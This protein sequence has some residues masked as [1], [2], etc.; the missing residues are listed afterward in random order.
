MKQEVSLYDIKWN[1]GDCLIFRAYLNEGKLKMEGHDFTSLSESMFGDEE[2]EYFYFFNQENT[3]KL[4]LL[5]HNDDLLQGLLD[6]FNNEIKNQE[7]IKLCKDNNIAY[8]F[9][10]WS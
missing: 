7:F 2:Y 3:K 10:S 8:D 5:L 6:F 4:S 1:N 9:S